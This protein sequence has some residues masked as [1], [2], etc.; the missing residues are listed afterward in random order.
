MPAASRP[1]PAFTL[2]ELLVVIAIIAVLIG[3]LLPAVQKVREAAARMKC[4]NNLKQ[5]GLAIH[6]FH[7]ANGVFPAATTRVP[8]PNFWMHGPTWWVYTLPF[9]EQD[10]VFNRTVLQNQAGVNNTFW[11]ADAGAVNKGPY[12][13]I[14]F[15]MS[16]CPS[17]P[18]PEWNIINPETGPTGYR[19]Y[20]PTYTCIL[21]SARHP[22]ADTAASNG[23]ISDG[24][25]IGLR[26]KPQDGTRMAQITDGTSNTVMVGE[27]SDWANPRQTDPIYDDI[28]SSD[29]RGAFMGTS[30]VTRPNGPGSLAGCKG[31]GPTVRNNNCMRCYNTTTIV[32]PI[33]RKQFQFASMGDQRCGTPLQSAHP[34]GA[35]MLFADGH[36]QFLTNSTDLVTLQ[37]L[38]DKDD[39]N[40]VNLP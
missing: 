34:N 33:G 26:H 28:R 3:L 24:G 31:D 23:P 18:L 15:P 27:Q 37:N 6:N 9:V 38:V 16:R 7:D 19:A 14:T 20:E 30:Y 1:R 40:V 32:W 17:S 36:V 2:I 12:N 5:L 11:F 21:G 4:S 8:D 35:M 39:G 29:S 22:S 10:N 13:G 25:V